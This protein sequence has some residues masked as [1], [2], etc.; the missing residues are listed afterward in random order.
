MDSRS[1]RKKKKRTWL[2]VLVA[3]I[4]ILIIGIAA[5]IF[6]TLHNVKT[7]VNDKIHEPVTSIDK[8][9]SDKKSKDSKPLNIL[10]MGID[11]DTERQGIGR[12]DALIVLTLNPEQE[13]MQ[14]VSIP[15][16]TRTEL[17]QPDGGVYNVDKINHSFAFGKAIDNT[18][19]SGADMTVATV[20]NFLDIDVDFYVSINMDGL[21]ELVDQV[22]GVTVTNT[23]AW[24]DKNYDFPKGD[25]QLD[26]KKA[27]AYVRMRKDDPEGDFGR[28][29]RQRQIIQGIIDKGAS[30][31]TVGKIN[32]V[33]DVLGNNMNTNMDYEN[34]K[35]M[36]KNYRNARRN[37]SEYIMEG[38]GSNIDGVYYLIV[39]EAEVS[40]T[41]DMIN[42][43][44]E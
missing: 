6:F 11:E 3:I 42:D 37:A 2:K 31:G 41:H 32:G 15:R 33:I 26:G 9:T 17:I 30:V 44:H 12:A 20:E 8:D 19:A 27:L 29:R 1:G 25:V 14:M 10:L 38:Q 23:V 40:K 36:L 5:F 22:G 43:L 35:T 18:D 24:T 7:T 28:T 16:D 39:D 34:M 4:L 13:K 21:T